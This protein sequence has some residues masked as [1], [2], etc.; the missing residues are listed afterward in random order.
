MGYKSE[1]YLYAR[2]PELCRAITARYQQWCQ[3]NK[4]SKIA[5]RP[6]VNKEDVRKILEELLMG[7]EDPLPSVSEI[8]KRFG[9]RNATIIS[10]HFPELC[11]LIIEKRRQQSCLVRSIMVDIPHLIFLDSSYKPSYVVEMKG[12]SAF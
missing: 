8:G 11:K 10:R 1:P 7:S 3:D 2:A 4:I 5:P 9:Y 12:I 6:F